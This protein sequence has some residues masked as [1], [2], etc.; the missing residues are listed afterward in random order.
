MSAYGTKRTCII[1]ARRQLLTLSGLL[2]SAVDTAWLGSGCRRGL[3][4]ENMD[5]G[6]S[7]PKLAVRLTTEPKNYVAFPNLLIIS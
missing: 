1:S 7:P 4:A 2:L 5:E 3:L 6:M